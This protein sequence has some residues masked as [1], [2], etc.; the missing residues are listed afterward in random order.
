MKNASLHNRKWWNLMGSLG[1]NIGAMAIDARDP[2]IPIINAE[3]VKEL[4]Q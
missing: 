3:Q 4:V 1:F 2:S